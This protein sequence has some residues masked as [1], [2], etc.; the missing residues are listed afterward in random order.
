TGLAWE[1]L[2]VEPDHHAGERMHRL[3]EAQ[4]FDIGPGEDG[5]AL[6]GHAARVV[7]R[8]EL[9][10]LRARCGLEAREQRAQ[11]EADPRHDQ[12][13]GLDATEA[14]GTLFER[15]GLENVLE[16]E[17]PLDLR[18]AVDRDAPGLGLQKVR[19]ALRVLLLRAEL[20]EV[21]VA[22]D[23]FELVW[24]PADDIARMAGVVEPRSR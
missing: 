12:R 17:F 20:V 19:V 2:A 5:D 11:G 9:D 7:Q 15:M 23:L 18:L 10:V 22:R 21:V 6:P 16:R 14:V 3:V 13:P 4:S 1:S 24:R 8:R